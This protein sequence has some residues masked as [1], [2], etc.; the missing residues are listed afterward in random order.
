MTNLWRHKARTL[1]TA[2]GIA[3][4]VATI[5]ALLSVGSG[6]KRTAGELVHLGQADLGVFQSGVSDPTASLLPASLGRRLQARGDVGEVAPLLL[7]IEGVKADPA[8][9]VF[10]AQPQG[11]FAR[12]LVIPRGTTG[13]GR[14]DVLVGERLAGELRLRPGQTTRIKGKPFTI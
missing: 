11:F 10:G 9:V 1:A 5:V 2:L 7:V 8:A 6:L 12:R 3:L 4:G 14:R 13:L